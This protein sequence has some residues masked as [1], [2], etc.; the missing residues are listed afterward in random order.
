MNKRFA[1]RLLCAVIAL[2]FAASQAF[3]TPVAELSQDEP[4]SKSRVAAISAISAFSPGIALLVVAYQVKKERNSR[5]EN[6]WLLN[7]LWLFW[8]IA[9]VD[10]ILDMIPAVSQVNQFV[11]Y[12]IIWYVAYVVA[13]CFNTDF[14]MLI[15]A[16][17]GSGV[18]AGRHVYSSGLDSATGGAAS[19]FRSMLENII[20]AISV[21]FLT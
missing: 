18:Q 8:I 13:T 7:L 6:D 21:Y 17:L 10:F 14:P 5:G 2:V 19:P 3:G 4:L 9:F 20:T 16:L 1:I 15:G 12:G 11:Q